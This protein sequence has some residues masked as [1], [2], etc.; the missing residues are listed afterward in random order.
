M[1]YPLINQKEEMILIPEIEKQ[2][3]DPIIIKTKKVSSEKELEEEIMNNIFEFMN[4]LGIGYSLYGR[5]YRININNINYYI[6]FVFYNKTL[7]HIF[8]LI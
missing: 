2:L 5:Q 1:N 8:F 3:K 7:K 6:D 4:E